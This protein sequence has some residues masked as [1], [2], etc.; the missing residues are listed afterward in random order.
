MK[1]I[2][3]QFRTMDEEICEILVE[4]ATTVAEAIHELMQK[5]NLRNARGW[6]LFIVYNDLIVKALPREERLVG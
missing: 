3:C 4:S 2:A 5:K 1:K 6:S